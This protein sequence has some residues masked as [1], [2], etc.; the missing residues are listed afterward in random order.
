MYQQLET[1]VSSPMVSLNKIVAESYLHNPA[2]GLEQIDLL[3]KNQALQNYYLLYAAE[4]DMLLRQN[5]A[6]LARLA[7]SKAYKLAISPLDKQ[8][9]ENKMEQC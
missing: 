3:K 7:F 4:G 2:F 9:L 5:N 6:P 1:L 8:F